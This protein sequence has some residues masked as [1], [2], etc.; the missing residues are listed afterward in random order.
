MQ[1][2]LIVATCLAFGLSLNQAA[3][4]LGTAEWETA[5]TLEPITE[6]GSASYLRSKPYWPFIGRGFIQL[7]WKANY[8]KAGALIG[9]DLVNDPE[10]AL[11]PNNAAKILVLGMKQG[12]FTGRKLADYIN[13]TA[14]DFV[15]ARRIVNGTDR[16]TEIAILAKKY[17]AE[18]K[19]ESYGVTVKAVAFVQPAP[20]PATPRVI[21]AALVDSGS[22]TINAADLQ[23]KV[24]AVSGTV[25]AG[26]GI[27]ASISNVLQSIPPWG[28]AVLAIA[29]IAGLY[30]LTHRIILARIEDAL[31][32]ANTGRDIGL[33]PAAA[34]PAPEAQSITVSST[35]AVTSSTTISA[36]PAA[37]PAL[38]ATDTPEPAPAVPDANAGQTDAV[39]ADPA[40][41]AP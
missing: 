16:A 25:A 20:I 40:A 12:W 2:P 29:V 8:E 38:V 11:E 10:L 6:M 22:R 23:N 34:A 21:K 26:T 4:V 3:Y 1:K 33:V 31:T 15:G 36:S 9:A 37:D 39:A 30:L 14:C 18:L 5:H 35:T 19:A 41:V 13:G 27:V 28:Y 32:G 17:Q 7:T 24:Y